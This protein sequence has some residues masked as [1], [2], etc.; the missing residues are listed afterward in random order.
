MKTALLLNAVDPS[1]GGVLIRGQKGTAKSTAARGL[2]VFGTRWSQQEAFLAR[3][4]DRARLYRLILKM[5]F[6]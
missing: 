3:Q 5:E 2:A 1:I 4:I 6:S